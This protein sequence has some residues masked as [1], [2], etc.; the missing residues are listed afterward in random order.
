M[1]ARPKRDCG[2]P[3]IKKAVHRVLV[4]R[5]E[6]I[7][8]EKRIKQDF[9]VAGHIVTARIHQHQIAGLKLGKFRGN[10]SQ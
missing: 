8:F 7:D 2:A 5:F 4:D 3:V 6:M 9:D 10:R 1:S